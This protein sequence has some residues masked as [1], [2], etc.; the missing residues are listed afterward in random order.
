MS[1]QDRR[2]Q[3]LELFQQGYDLQVAGELDGAIEHYLQSIDLYPTAEAHTF[4]GWTYSVRGRIDEAIAECKRAIAVDPDFGNPYNDIGSYLIEQERF[5]EAIGWLERAKQ[6]RRY[7]PRHFPYLN[8]G[9]L[10]LERGELGRALEEFRGAKALCPGDPLA[11][12]AI[13]AIRSRMN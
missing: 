2:T 1:P 7:G 9:R 13:S 4:L 3:A 10:Y 12:N 5:D 8:L 6:A 11:A